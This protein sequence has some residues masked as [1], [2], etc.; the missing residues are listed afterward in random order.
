MPIVLH[1]ATKGWP[2]SNITVNGIIIYLKNQEL[3]IE[4]LCL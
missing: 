4:I 3:K 1:I 2:T